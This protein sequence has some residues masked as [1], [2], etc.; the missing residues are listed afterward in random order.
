MA[1]VRDLGWCIARIRK[2]HPDIPDDKLQII[3]PSYENEPA[4]CVEIS[5]SRDIQ[6]LSKFIHEFYDRKDN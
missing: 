5:G 3:S 6:E 1:M 2:G 4:Q